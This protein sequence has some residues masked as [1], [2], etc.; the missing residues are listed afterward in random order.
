MDP[1]LTIDEAAAYLRVSKTSLRRWTRDG[2]LECVRIG[3]R[4][5]RRFRQS[6]LNAFLMD[7]TSG[8]PRSEVLPDRAIGA[9]GVLDAAAGQGIPRHVSLHHAGREELWKLFRPYVAGHLHHGAAM[10]YIHEEGARDEVLAGLRA[11]GLDPEALEAAGRLRLL[12]PREA[13]LR[14]GQFVATEMIAFME[15]AVIAFRDAGHA[16]VL[17]SGEM[18]WYLSGAPGV[19]EMIAYEDLLNPLLLR[20]PQVTI[21]CHYDVDRLPGRITLG[22]LCTHYHAQLTDR[23]ADG[24]AA[25]LAAR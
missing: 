12:V 5:E 1:L 17:I 13:Y 24:F 2:I 9:L 8:A 16:R 20:Y 11:E 19:E 22:A 7:R 23:L 3:P 18:T 15:A 21:V 14:T 10:L 4:A 25:P 6:V